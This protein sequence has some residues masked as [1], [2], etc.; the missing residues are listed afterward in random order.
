M[1]KYKSVES[2]L[3]MIQGHFITQGELIMRIGIPTEIKTRKPRG[4]DASGSSTFS[5]KWS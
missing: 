5:T 4:N 1:L 2:A 3:K